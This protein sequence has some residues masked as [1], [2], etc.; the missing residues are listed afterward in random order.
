[1]RISRIASLALVSVLVATPAH[2]QLG[3]LMKRAAQKA[4][5]KKT[6][7]KVAEQMG[8]TSGGYASRPDGA[9]ATEVSVK[10]MIDAL[11]ATRGILDERDALVPQISA[12]QDR[13]S[14]LLGNDGRNALDH[15]E[16]AHR[17]VDDC[18]MKNFQQYVQS[19]QAEI[20]A[21][22][23]MNMPT[24]KEAQLMVETGQ[25][26]Q[27]A[28]MKGDTATTNR[29]TIQVRNNEL[30]RYGIDWVRD[31]SAAAAKC[32]AY[33]KPAPWMAEYHA[34]EA[35]ISS[36]TNKQRQLEESAKALMQQKTGLTPTDIGLMREKMQHWMDYRQENPGKVIPGVTKEEA[37]AMEAVLRSYRK[38]QLK[39]LL[40]VSM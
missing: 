12:L 39:K 30:K 2:A 25:K 21:K 26:I 17:D 8:S 19:R 9:P 24:S 15:F 10:A 3:G 40:D 34:N 28:A 5:E 4:V 27:A 38:D 11:T 1:M 32:P 16:Q 36:M 6:E 18:T 14:K 35:K 37:D 31:S 20:M 13:Q 22:G 23:A 29:L 7:G 33:P